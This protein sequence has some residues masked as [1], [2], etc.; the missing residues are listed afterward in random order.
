M[1]VNLHFH[2]NLSRGMLNQLSE[3]VIPRPPPILNPMILLI[4]NCGEMFLII[5]KNPSFWLTKI[6]YQ[7]LN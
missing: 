4:L 2:S 3:I 5:N 6:E 1:R 7:L